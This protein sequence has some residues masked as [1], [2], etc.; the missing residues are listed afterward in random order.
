M[1][2]TPEEAAATY[3]KASPLT[4]VSNDAPPVLTLHGDQDK[5]VPVDQATM[6]DDKM[7]AAGAFHTLKIFKGQ[8]HGFGGEHQ[9]EAMKAMWEFFDQHLSK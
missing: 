6:L 3:E 7:K 1:S 2:G 4:Y 5:L 9:Q 8:G